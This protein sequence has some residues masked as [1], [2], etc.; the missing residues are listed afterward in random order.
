MWLKW[1]KREVVLYF[2]VFLL[3]IL[4][5]TCFS[6]LLFSFTLLSTW[7]L[8][9][10][11]FPT[12]DP[13]LVPCLLSYDPTPMSNTQPQHNAPLRE[14]V[15]AQNRGCWSS[16]SWHQQI[17]ASQSAPGSGPFC[18][19]TATS[20]NSSWF[21]SHATPGVA[22]EIHCISQPQFLCY[23]SLCEHNLLLPTQ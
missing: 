20:V 18:D 4:L 21:C 16:G 9:E 11:S 13:L 12:S 6:L 1:D 8:N 22:V 7:F 2:S 10:C 17:T 14:K 5:P 3:S 15:N 23:C 19:F